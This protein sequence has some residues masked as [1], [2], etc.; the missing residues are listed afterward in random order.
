[1]PKKKEDRVVTKKIESTFDQFHNDEY[2]Q[3]NIRVPYTR[4]EANYR[5]Y[6]LTRMDDAR[7]QREN[8]HPEFND[9]NYSDWYD[10][11]AK[12]AN[13]YNPPKKNKE[14]TRIVTGTTTEKENTLLSALLNYNL[15]PNIT[16][17]DKNDVRIQELGKDMEDMIAKSRDIE[18]YEEKRPLVYKELLDQGTCFVEEVKQEQIIVEKVMKGEAWR[19]GNMKMS[20]LKWE[21]RLKKSYAQCHV[22][23][24]EGKKVYLGNIREFHL[25]KQPYAFIHDIIPYDTAKYI[26]GDWDRWKYV[27]KNIEYFDPEQLEEDNYRDWTLME[28][29]QDMVEVVKY[30]DPINNEFMIL[31]NGVMMLPTEFPLTSVSPSGKFTF[32]KGDLEPISKFFAVSRSIPAKTKVDQGT[33]DEF[34]RLMI[35]KTRQ[36]FKPPFINASNR[37]L[38]DKIFYP[39]TITTGV[40]PAKLQMLGENK[41]VNAAEFNMFDL[42]KKIVDEKSVSPTFSGDLTQKGTTATEIMET[43]RQQMMKMGST[44]LGIISLERQLTELRIHN[45]LATWTEPIDQKV[46]DVRKQLIDIYRTVSI[47]AE[48]E[49]G[50]K[51]EKVISFDPQLAEEYSSEQIMKAEDNFKDQ[52][53]NIR[54]IFM[55]PEMLRTI[56]TKWHINITPTERD[57]SDLDRVLFIQN[58]QDAATIFG[59]QAIN[60]E[61]AKERFASLIG[62]DPEKFFAQ[63]EAQAFPGMQAEMEGG[64]EGGGAVPAQIE[65]AVS[66]QVQQP[67]LKQLA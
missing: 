56:E 43:K 64:A 45:I 60:M 52:G 42:V 8:E 35:L 37:A 3:P 4:E 51:G 34:F 9:M 26:Y 54:F 22:N 15:E 61:H 44:I 21:R 29:E 47:E 27:K 32:A 25:N 65:G 5:G 1:M 50:Q 55:D 38:S 18:H 36:S 63:G 41:G 20:A 28:F 66:N 53:R 33:L 2:E 7:D 10:D 13:S 57:S 48:F 16:A 62:E 19:K 31:L 23:L 39:G 24:L 40:N 6:L 12:A 58:I 30:Q 46:D 49:N 67:S 59:P 11:N 17:F 14:D